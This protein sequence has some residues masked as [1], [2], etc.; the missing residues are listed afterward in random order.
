[1]RW[2]SG[3]HQAQINVFATRFKNYILLDA[4]GNTRGIDA[5]LN[6]LDA[7]GDGIADGSGEEI[8]PEF[9]Y[10]QVR[11]R[12]HGFEASGNWRLLDAANKLD[13]QWRLDSTRATN[14]NTGAPLPRI[15]PL[16]T[17]ATL[18]WTQG[19]W[20]ARVGFDRNAK[21]RDNSA[22]GY[23]LWNLAATWRMKAKDAQ[24]QWF[25]RLD[26]VTDKL[27]Y[28]ATSILTTSAPNRSPLPGRSFK[29]GLQAVF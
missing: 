12:F 22:E 1:L 15:S 4:T 23:T 26:N 18:V 17:G 11:V 24:L 13:L 19:P 5:E 9:A 8:L 6:P 3:A 14:A 27:A 7:D 29:L 21:A 10:S 25:A 28:S 16:R 20:S 2:S